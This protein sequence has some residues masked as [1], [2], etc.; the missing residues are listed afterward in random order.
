MA[1]ALALG[2]E[3]LVAL[4]VIDCWEVIVAGAVYKPSD[5]SVPKGGDTS[6][7]TSPLGAFATWA[8][9]FI[10]PPARS[11]ADPGLRESVTG[12]N[13]IFAVANF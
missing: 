12:I 5:V 13:V 3:M 6:Q 1:V 7:V 10:A 9:N 8:A 2:Y 11:T 4:I